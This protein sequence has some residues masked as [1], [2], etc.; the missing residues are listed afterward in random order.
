MYS[1]LETLQDYLHLLMIL[2]QLMRRD[3]IYSQRCN[4]SCPNFVEKDWNLLQLTIM[5]LE[6]KINKIK[7][8][9]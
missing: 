5:D 3:S 8:R 7:N 4:P 1:E 6:E 2:D 9:K